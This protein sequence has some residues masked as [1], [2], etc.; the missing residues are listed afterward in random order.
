MKKLY[1]AWLHG[2]KSDAWTY[3]ETQALGLDENSEAFLNFLYSLYEVKLDME[4]D[5]DTG[6][7]RIL[8][9]NGV[10]LVEPAKHST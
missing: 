2:S 4:L 7:T 6:D 3:N 10:K 1:T 9:V 5:T 8:A